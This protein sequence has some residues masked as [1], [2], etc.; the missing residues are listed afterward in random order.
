M[1]E[2]VAVATVADKKNPKTSTAE[3][4]N[5]LPDMRKLANSSCVT[6]R[7]IPT[8]GVTRL[9]VWHCQTK[10]ARMTI[11]PIICMGVA[12]PGQAQ[13]LDS[14]LTPISGCLRGAGLLHKYE[15]SDKPS[16]TASGCC[17][18][19]GERSGCL[20]WQLYDVGSRNQACWL[21]PKFAL[22]P[23]QSGEN[24]TSSAMVAPPN[25][26]R[27]NH[28]GYAGIWVQHGFTNDLLNQS[29]VLGGDSAVRWGDVEIANDVWDWSATDMVFARQAAAGFYIE[30][31]L[32]VGDAAPQWL[33]KDKK[34]GGGG[35][36]PVRVEVKKGFSETF[37]S[38]LE[39][40]Y[41]F[42]FLRAVDRFAESIVRNENG[43][44][45]G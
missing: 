8:P 35:V 39:Q 30:T 5:D 41:Q 13:P 2:V 33:Y 9:Q 3:N 24:C 6:C 16:L 10:L 38:Y 29:F 18:A 7:K 34:D 22:K 21:L 20:G 43:R 42:Y 19:C 27:A 4:E 36:T 12:L 31:A 23:Q 17:A 28:S 40:S 32:M 11:L 44:A 45:R 14:C 1:T 25:P 15:P 37:P 26:A